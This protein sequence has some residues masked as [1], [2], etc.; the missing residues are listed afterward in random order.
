MSNV[1]IRQTLDP[2]LKQLEEEKSIDVAEKI[3]SE[4][5][6]LLGIKVSD[7]FLL[8]V[9]R[10]DAELSRF[11]LAP[12]FG[13][14]AAAYDIPNDHP[15]LIDL[16]LF[17]I[18][19]TTKTNLSWLIGITP[20]FEDSDANDY[21]NISIDFIFPESADRL[22]ILISDKFKI[23]S[24]ELKDHVTHTQFEIFSNWQ[25][26]K[27][28]EQKDLQE[29]KRFVH[30]RLW[31]SF[32][33]EPIN[34]AFYL[35]LVESFSL[36]VHH[37]EGAFGRKPTV[38]FTTRLIGRLLF[39][40]FL[41]KK[42]YICKD[43]GYFEVEGSE[44][45]AKYY[46][47]KLEIL[48][49]EVL[50]REISERNVADKITPY[51]N[52]GLF[53]INHTD[54][55]QDP[56]LTFP[57]GYFSSLFETLNKYNFTVDESSPEFQHVAVDPEMLGRIFESLLA[58]QVDEVSGSN[59]KKVTGAFYTPREIV[60]YMCEESLI[61][62]LK[63]K[64]PQS[65]DRD[66]RIQELV[67][68][69][70]TIFRDQASNKRQAWKPYTEA[71]IKALSGS[72]I[73][74][75][76]TVLDPAVGSGAFPMG[77]LQLLVK[78]YS[79]LDVQYEKN[80][81]KLKRE[82]LAKSLYGIDIEQTAIEIC[83]LRAWLSIIVDVPE[84]EAIEPLPNLDFK[85][86][87]ANTLIP[88]DSGEQAALF[89]DHQLKEKLMTIRD[90]YFLTS[91]KLKKVKL[92][93][94]Y[95]KLTHQEGIFDSKRTKQ[96]KSYRPF[97]ISVGSDFYDPE[98]H[99]GISSFDIVIGNPPYVSTKGVEAKAK[100]DLEEVYGFSDD[101][102][103][104]F[105]FKSFDLLKNK[106]LLAFITSKTFWTIQTK[107]NVR[108][109]LLG[110]RL[111]FLY[112]TSNPFDSAMV[113]T[114]VVLASKEKVSENKIDFLIVDDDYSNPSKLV[115]DKALYENA[116]NKVIFVPT[117]ENKKI[118]QKLNPIVKVLIEKWWQVINSSKSISKNQEKI[119]AY[120]G[121][122]KSGD[123][124]LMGLITDGGQGLATANNGRFLG[125]S[126][127]SK[128]AKK[129]Q[130]SRLEK[131]SEFLFEKKIKTYGETKERITQTLG[132]LSEFELRKAL[133]SLREEY[134]RDIFGQ[135]YIYKIINE[136]EI[137]SVDSMT[138][139]E[140]LNGIEGVRCF[141]PYDK[142]D[143][144]GNR[145]FLKTPF[146]IDWSSDAVGYLKNNSG[147]KGNGS[148]RYQN[149]QFYFRA[150]FCWILTLNEQSEYQKARIKEAG[151]FDVNA[152]SLFPTIPLVSVKYL[153]CLLNSYLI[154][155]IKR[156]LINSSSAFQINDARQIPVVIP[157][158]RELSE[159]DDLFDRASAIK[160]KQYAGTI[161]SSEADQLLDLI[162]KEL[163][164]KVYS[165]Y[166]LSDMIC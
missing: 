123:I 55:Y 63:E 135:G 132:N 41:K 11:M 56:K 114:C 29:A 141:V 10:I 67:K 69:P 122:L 28:N 57:P 128:E 104:H 91:N 12:G 153:V 9:P 16:K 85:F 83:R 143:K 23:R 166:D 47:S 43:P 144:D 8:N 32:N 150:G 120:Q 158:S 96:L 117:S 15:D 81:S 165:L 93:A 161:E 115:V 13:R 116:V 157:S 21:K 88:L 133:D 20:N 74:Q 60:S 162:Q 26:V 147:N 100:K 46:R 14:Q 49:F 62:F 130:K 163:D 113:D 38:M 5:V 78:V 129:I 119:V 131:A 86:A 72:E 6:G 75:P 149:S 105:Y 79:R 25:N 66:L 31:E 59:K 154:F 138:D 65:P 103:S 68:L 112:D 146:L 40:W 98:V 134:G 61:E 145:W 35:D 84:S 24:L 142:G 148:T 80:I 48:F 89:D 76:L 160:T 19:K 155:Q 1:D 125:V 17:W 108:D 71:A 70:E 73:N 51:L 37:L 45:Q 34:R 27:I 111:L 33:F 18:K 127:T 159:F 22:I 151:V 101:L 39:L 30:S 99:H 36:L 94:E 140:K 109:L 107:K 52:G 4:L 3:I 2:L 7:R 136:S 164:R 58:E 118:Y 102:Y 156:N 92:Q 77:M 124:T 110:N 137:A 95:E 44:D 97:D 90:D 50:N 121:T 82:I 87:C 126:S 106:G 152:M 53:D 54:F 64:L 139:D 42:N